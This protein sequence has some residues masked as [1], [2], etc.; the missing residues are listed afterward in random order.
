MISPL[1]A[2]SFLHWFDR[3]FHG[4]D[5]P[6]QFAGAR[7]TRYAD[8]FVVMAKYMGRRIVDWIEYVIE[9]RL[10]LEINREKTKIVDMKQRGA[11]LDFLG[12]SFRY[13]A[14]L[15][16]SSR[17]Y[18]NR[19]PSRESMSRARDR[20]R[21]LTSSRQGCHSIDRVVARL[22]GFLRGWKSY[23]GSGY[24]RK[25]FRSI[26]AFVAERVKRFPE[27]RSQRPFKPPKG[28]SWYNFIYKELQVYQL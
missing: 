18:L 2:N 20:I 7:L 25:A 3:A 26:N 16:G 28:M 24:P 27:R 14:D 15:F 6:A 23:F 9:A 4:K 17:R 5:G 22:N 13:D 21:D 12:Y 19:F 11:I 8:D 10:G 1:L